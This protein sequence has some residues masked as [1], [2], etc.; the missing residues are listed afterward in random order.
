MAV[1]YR[2]ARNGEREPDLGWLTRHR[3]A[4]PE[5]SGPP[6]ETAWARTTRSRTRPTS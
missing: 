1:S 4:P 2:E 5:T 3:A 6:K